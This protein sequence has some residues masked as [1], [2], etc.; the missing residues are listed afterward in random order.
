M[1]QALEG[2]QIDLVFKADHDPLTGLVPRRALWT[3]LAAVLGR[4]PRRGETVAVLLIDLDDFKT[5]NDTLGHEGGDELRRLVAARL[6]ETVRAG[7]LVARHGGDEFAI[8]LENCA[9]PTVAVDVARRIVRAVA[10]PA[11]VAATIIPVSVS[12]GLAVRG[13][14]TDPDTLMRQADQAMY[15]AKERGKNRVECYDPA[16]PLSSHDGKTA[17]S[18]V[19]IRFRSLCLKL[20][21]A[22]RLSADREGDAAE[23]SSR[24]LTWSHLF[25]R[26]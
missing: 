23:P 1:V 5:V 10:A 16:K 8:L 21:K 9:D 24:S 12:I 4:P 17:G 26:P 2:N 14:T 6:L 18:S 19:V 15:A 13:D 25:P 22:R 3:R 20:F 7:D 11:Q